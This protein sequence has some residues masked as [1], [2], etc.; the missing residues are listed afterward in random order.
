MGRKTGRAGDTKYLEK[1]S[2]DSKEKEI[3]RVKKT[4]GEFGSERKRRVGR[5]GKGRKVKIE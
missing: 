2:V 4:K 1:G 5:E 3:L